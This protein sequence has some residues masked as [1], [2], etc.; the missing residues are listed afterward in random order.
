METGRQVFGRFEITGPLPDV[1]ELERHAAVEVETGRAV[2]L[3]RPTAL[4]A[5]RPKTRQQFRAVWTPPAGAPLP[6]ARLAALAVGDLDGRPAAV[7]PR[8]HGAPGTAFR[9]DAAQARELAGFILPALTVAPPPG[10]DLTAHDLLLDTDGRPWLAP[11]GV[12][13]KATITSPPIHLPPSPEESE[14]DRARYGFGVFL[15]KAVTGVLPFEPTG[16]VAILRERQQTPTPAVQVAPG[17]PDDL[18]TLLDT[19]V[20]P[21]AAHRARAATPP[22]T[23]PPVLPMMERAPRPRPQRA[24]HIRQPPSAR[25]DVPLGAFAIVL[26]QRTAT[27]ASRRRLAALLDRPSDAFVLPAGAPAEVLVEAT[28]TLEQAQARMAALAPAGAPLAI[29]STEPP[30]ATRSLLAGGA[31]GAVLLLPT[32]LLF[33]SVVAGLGALLSVG[34]AVVGWRRWREASHRY[35]LLQRTGKYTERGPQPAAALSDGA[36]MLSLSR[37]AQA[38][39]KAILLA[40]LPEPVRVDLLESVDELESQGGTDAAAVHQA[41]DEIGD[42]ART[43]HQQ[44]HSTDSSDDALTRARRAVAAARKARI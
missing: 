24:P 32:A 4:A 44:P 31:T 33:G 1:G 18:R 19:L 40:D 41:L 39:R 5:L 11:S 12:P 35:T 2:E 6:S 10:G 7:R 17:L 37:R 29:R 14:V 13:P 21:D 27:A 30:P 43:W 8:M 36:Q 22:P 28:T 15:Y 34:A 16:N 25:R 20:H 26:D 23:G 42:A 3:I 38:T 9:L